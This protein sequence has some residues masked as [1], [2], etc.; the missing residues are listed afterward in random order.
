[1]EFA[2]NMSEIKLDQAISMLVSVSVTACKKFEK[3]SFCILLH[4]SYSE[5]ALI[6][7]KEV[8]LN[9]AHFFS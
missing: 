3:A 8:R 7:E 9:P 1:M 2:V 4:K 6:N 5:P